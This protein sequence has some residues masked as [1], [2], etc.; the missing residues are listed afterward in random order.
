MS[1]A[2]TKFDQRFFQSTRGRIVLLLRHAAM[3]VNDLAAELGLTDNAVR[4][5]LLSLERDALVK[6][7]GSVKG[8]RRPHVL[9]RLTDE[10]R[11][12][13]PKA[14]DSLLNRLLDVLKRRVSHSSLENIFRDVGSEI[15]SVSQAHSGRTLDE[16]VD[17]AIE[18]LGTLGGSAK[19]FRSA[20]GLEIRSESCPFADAVAEHPE[21]C[22][23][24]ESMVAE[25]TGT[26]VREC[27]DR[28]SLPKC[29]FVLKMAA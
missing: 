10:A 12:I 5:H 14:Y 26:P 2:R 23:V 18:T 4:A 11:H 9:Y 28:T 27:C 15:A 6:V 21:I 29:R 17:I 24:A 1:I 25:I 3:T 16:K 22:K 8:V 20:D 13:F 7:G 19:A